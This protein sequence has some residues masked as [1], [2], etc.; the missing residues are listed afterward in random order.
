MPVLPVLLMRNTSIVS[1]P[2]VKNRLYDTPCAVSVGVG[3]LG[4][5][6]GGAQEREQQQGESEQSGHAIR[7]SPSVSG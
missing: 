6:V 1:S 3:D 4:V 5:R 2:S 7:L